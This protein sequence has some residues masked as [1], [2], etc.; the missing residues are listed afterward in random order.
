M[1]K[2]LVELLYRPEA[3]EQKYDCGRAGAR[4]CEAVNYP[5]EASACEGQELGGLAPTLDTDCSISGPVQQ[6]Y[7]STDCEYH[8]FVHT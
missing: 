7:V 1:P 5:R 3:A 4:A 6:P 2:K 8:Y